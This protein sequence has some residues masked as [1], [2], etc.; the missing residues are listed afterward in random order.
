[1]SIRLLV[2]LAIALSLAACVTGPEPP[3]IAI[4]CDADAAH[5]YAGQAATADV[6]E[7]AR[8]AAGA[9][10]VRTLKPGQVV[11]MEFRDGRLNLHVDSAN[12]IVRAT[13]G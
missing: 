9:E 13:C 11:T 12:A 7:A 6:V 3:S 4:G 2:L 10:I 1:M 8:K 5:A